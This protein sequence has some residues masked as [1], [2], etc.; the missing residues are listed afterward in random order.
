MGITGRD[1]ILESKTESG[2]T[3]LLQLG[4]GGCKLQVQVRIRYL[5]FILLSSQCLKSSLIIYYNILFTP[6]SVL[7]LLSSMIT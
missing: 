4:F 1:T 7:M 2:I 5:N 3:E 6:K